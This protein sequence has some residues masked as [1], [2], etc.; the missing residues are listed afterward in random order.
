M[1]YLYLR[2]YR[3]NLTMQP[4]EFNNRESHCLLGMALVYVRPSNRD[5]TVCYRD[6]RHLS[7][8]FYRMLIRFRNE[9]QWTKLQLQSFVASY[10]S[11]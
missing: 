1:P 7:L 5:L 4:R 11:N 3:G 6:S 9:P 10:Q 2:G 8:P